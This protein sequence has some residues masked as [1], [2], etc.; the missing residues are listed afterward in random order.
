MKDPRVFYRAIDDFGRRFWEY[1][2][3]VFIGEQDRYNNNRYETERRG[4][5]IALTR[6]FMMGRVDRHYD[7]VAG[8][9]LFESALFHLNGDPPIYADM[10]RMADFVDQSAVR[11]WR[12]A[13]HDDLLSSRS[14]HVYCLAEP[15]VEY[16]LYFAQGGQAGIRGV[17]AHYAADWFDPRTARFASAGGQDGEGCVSFAAPDG[18]DWVL[19]IHSKRDR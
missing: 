10:R 19:H 11:F 2:R 13:P 1:G 14:E 8:D 12:M 18:E 6:G 16:L 17:P 15:G 5:W 7:V 4:Y 9:R 3:P